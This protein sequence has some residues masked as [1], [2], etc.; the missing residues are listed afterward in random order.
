MREQAPAAR[1][2]YA[3]RPFESEHGALMA[4][5]SPRGIPVERGKIHEFANAIL[6]DHPHYHDENAARAAGLPSVVAPPTFV[7]ASALFE[8]SSAAPPAEIAGLDMRFALHAAQEFEFARPL[9]AGEVVT[10]EAGETRCYEKGGGRMKFV[11]F[12]TIFRDAKGEIVVRARTTA[13]QIKAPE[14]DA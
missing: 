10:G 3:T 5:I 14:K 8:G 6:D 1:N 7:M 9:C 12:E 11:E 2:R 4:K 13:I